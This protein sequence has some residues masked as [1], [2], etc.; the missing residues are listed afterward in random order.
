MNILWFDLETTGLD[1]DT[2]TIIEIGIVL[3]DIN[4]NILETWD[5][6]IK[7][8]AQRILLRHHTEHWKSMATLQRVGKM[9]QPQRKSHRLSERGLRASTFSVDTMSLTLMCHSSKHG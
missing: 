6:K 7:P 1:K 8:T 3:T 4:G 2:H 9:H 5:T